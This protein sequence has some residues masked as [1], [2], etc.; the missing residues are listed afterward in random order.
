MPMMVRHKF[1]LIPII[2]NGK[3]EPKLFVQK[4]NVFL[5]LRYG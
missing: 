3:K 1:H 2:L 4:K 5:L